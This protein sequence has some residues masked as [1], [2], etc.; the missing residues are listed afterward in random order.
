MASQPAAVAAATGGAS[1]SSV[2]TG[3]GSSVVTAAKGQ[4]KATP[5]VDMLEP[6]SRRAAFLFEEGL[7]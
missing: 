4:A 5:E 6:E 2:S 7:P 1:G 3:R